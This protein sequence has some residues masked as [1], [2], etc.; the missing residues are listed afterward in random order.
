MKH[1]LYI[2]LLILISKF[3]L[4]GEYGQIES[5]PFDTELEGLLEG[6]AAS[7]DEEEAI[8][9]APPESQ[10][11][12]DLAQP[13]LAQRLLQKREKSGQVPVEAKRK[14]KASIEDWIHENFS[15]ENHR[16]LIQEIIALPL[17][18]KKF[19]G[20]VSDFI[21][22]LGPSCESNPILGAF[23]VSLFELG[24]DGAM[25]RDLI[26]ELR[27]GA[28]L[29][30]AFSQN[31]AQRSHGFFM[32]YSENSSAQQFMTLTFTDAIKNYFLTV[33]EK[34]SEPADFEK[35]KQQCNSIEQALLKQKIPNQLPSL[36]VLNMDLLPDLLV[37]SQEINPDLFGF[38]DGKNERLQLA[39]LSLLDLKIDRKSVFEFFK[40]ASPSLHINP[41][42]AAICI[43][44]YQL[45]LSSDQIHECILEL[46]GDQTTVKEFDHNRARVFYN[47]F[48]KLKPKSPK[49]QQYFASH[50]APLMVD[51]LEPLLTKLTQNSE[52]FPNKLVLQNLYRKYKKN[53]EE[54]QQYFVFMDA[55]AIDRESQL[56]VADE[57]LRRFVLTLDASEH[58]KIAL[59]SLFNVPYKG[60]SLIEEIRSLRKSISANT[61]IA[62]ISVY[63]GHLGV[64][65][66]NI[67][68]FIL[69]IRDGMEK[70]IA[71]GESTPGVM[72]A[73]YL[74]HF[75]GPNTDLPA[76]LGRDFS[77][78]LKEFFEPL[79]HKWVRS[80]AFFQNDEV[81]TKYFQD[82]LSKRKKSIVENA[83]PMPVDDEMYYRFR[84]IALKKDQS[85]VK[86]IDGATN[87][88]PFHRLLLFSLF[89]IEIATTK[90]GNTKKNLIE[91]IKDVPKS[92]GNN[93]YLLGGIIYL[94][95]CGLPSEEIYNFIVRIRGLE[96]VNKKEFTA[97]SPQSRYQSFLNQKQPGFRA[98]KYFTVKAFK[99]SLEEV[100]LPLMR[101]VSKDENAQF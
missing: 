78:I 65:S 30:I 33:I 47:N 89:T 16:Q 75:Q 57:D 77:E 40:T 17:Q 18:H 1:Y 6:T 53:S 51:N 44:L 38:F 46:R 36:P 101:I 45:G 62:A 66:R 26:I 55:G 82:A 21:K 81:L 88:D 54:L 67:Y 74:S 7:L 8:E 87:L 61:L 39:F 98:P 56:A 42:M 22:N 12:I 68:S 9:Q 2:F 71:F 37:R 73:K 84:E 92:F 27:E 49:V 99:K 96:R 63:L 4:T 3:G 31:Q 52:Q 10:N 93:P 90:S 58:E 95:H 83:A 23:M 70:H 35:F 94:R 29:S 72:F 32:D 25:I 24:I 91:I 13:L 5:H 64:E 11:E 48:L 69:K 50:F 97:E 59:L 60:H 19:Q 76:Y 80:D 34:Y 79:V 41:I 14:K 43:Y 85:L 100:F 15:D 86:W 28:R 20:T